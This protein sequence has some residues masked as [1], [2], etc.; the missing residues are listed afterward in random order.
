[1]K[2]THTTFRKSLLTMG[3]ISAFTAGTALAADT[4][5]A[6]EYNKSSATNYVA[7]RTTSGDLFSKGYYV[8]GSIGQSEA[9][10]YCDG[11]SGCEDNDTAWKVFGG[12]QVMDM[13]SVE[14]SYLNLGDIR[15]DGQNSDVSAFAA[16][17][18]GTLPVTQKFDVFAKLGGA[19]WTS[20]NTDGKETG[21]G[22]AYGLGAKMMLNPTTKLRAEW[23]TIKG[24]ETSKSEESDVNMLSIGVELNTL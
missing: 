19:R 21:F 20:E 3:L 15:K 2:F 18:V 8:G 9:T 24:V 5:Q 12:M 17:G 13:L 6:F 22:I 11:A 16:Y 14:G 7:S 4:P 23:E 1:M 10:S